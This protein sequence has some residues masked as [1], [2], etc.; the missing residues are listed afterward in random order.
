M[1]EAVKKEVADLIQDESKKAEARADNTDAMLKFLLQNAGLSL[2]TNEINTGGNNENGTM[3]VANENS[4][5][6]NSSNAKRSREIDTT[7]PKD[8]KKKQ[9]V[10]SPNDGDGDN[11]NDTEM[12]EVD[13]QR[14]DYWTTSGSEKMSDNDDASLLSFSK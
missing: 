2:P 11:S 7:T 5:N 8:A 14:K 3:M 6:E 12:D 10:V 4:G 9:N 1:N 13:D